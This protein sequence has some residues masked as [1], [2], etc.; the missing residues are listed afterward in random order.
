MSDLAITML[1]CF[2]SISVMVIAG[3]AVTAGELEAPIHV[4]AGGKPIDV[5]YEGHAAP[6]FG[7]ID[8][9]GVNDLL[10]GQFREGRLRIYRNLGTNVEPKF[11]TYVWLRDGAEDGRV[12]E[13]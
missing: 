8:D 9:D 13:G 6:F 1:R 12:P 7:D 10:V 5:E 11:E 4:T 3:G 2:V